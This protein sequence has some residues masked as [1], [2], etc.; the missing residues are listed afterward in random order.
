MK[1]RTCL[2]VAIFLT[3]SAAAQQS[4]SPAPEAIDTRIGTLSYEAGFP[5]EDTTRKLYDEVDFQRAVLAYQYAD[6]LV[7]FYSMN[8]GFKSIGVEDGDLILYDR[9]LDPKGIYLTGNTTTIYG[10]A[11]LDLEANGPMVVEVPP[12]PFLG[13]VLDL[14]QRPIAGID[15]SGGTFVV[16]GPEFNGEVPDGAQLVR[17]TTSLAS[18]F[19]RGLVLDGDEETAIAAVANSRVYPLSQIDNP[20][21]MRVVP[22]T[23]VA[24]DT[25]S[26]EGIEFWQRLD[27]ALDRVQAD[28]D[29]SLILSLLG[30]LGLV[31]NEPF[32]PD[33]RQQEILEDASEFG[34]LTSQA[35]SMAPRFEGITYY[36]GTQWEWVLELDPTLRG[37]FWRDL[38]ARTNYYFQA[39]MA[40]PAMKNKAIGRG[41]QYLRSSRDADGK[42][43]DGAN[44]YRLRVP[45]DPPAVVNW[46][47]T[48]YDYETRSQVQ[49]DANLAALSSDDDLQVNADG[50]VDL[51]FG[52]DAP[53]GL[54]S[55]WIKTIPG[56]GWW[57]WFRFY[58]PT[59][60]F[61]D[62]T[63]SLPDFELRD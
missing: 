36:P 61:F 43:L 56:R 37:E 14:W 23:G 17:S 63:W 22:A 7:S 25:I 10:M 60:P 28:A 48:V 19:A 59:E 2:V 6:P 42:W 15:G 34:W 20:P 45:A 55:N 38:E 58:G 26:P 12:S 27:E 9:F 44:T 4:Q 53:S 54:E 32:N 51:Y 62:K 52:P 18:F 11:W 46:S 29:G 8:V 50:S 16:A 49:T 41:S 30:P 3:T 35:I 39:T 5:T 31:R 13:A 1:V 57:V 21:E 47:I 40:L 33:A 24:I